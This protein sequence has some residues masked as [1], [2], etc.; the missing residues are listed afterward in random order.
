MFAE[1]LEAH[2]A[3]IAL[4]I[5][6]VMFAAFLSER[7]APEIVAAAAAAT[8]LGLGFLS[9]DEALAAFSNPAPITIAAMFILSGA[10][11]RTG[12][13][14]ALADLVVSRAQERPILSISAF[15]LISML[16]SAVVNNT[17]VVLVLIPVVIKLAKAIGVAPTRLLIPLSYTAI[18][19]GTL[20]LL[21]T[22]T[23]LLVDGVARQQ[24]L[25]PFGI[26]EITPYGIITALSGLATMLLLGKFLLPHREDAAQDLLLGE[27]EF[28][29]EVAL[30]SEELDGK[31]IADLAELNRP[32]IVVTGVR[33]GT[34]VTRSDLNA[35]ELKKGDVL[36]VRAPTSEVLTLNSLKDFRVGLRSAQKKGEDHI[37]VEAVVSPRRTTQGIPISSL[38][39]GRRFG[40]RILG[41]HR[42]NHIPGPE[43]GAVRLKAADKLLIEGPA[44]GFEELSAETELVSVSHPTG[45]AYRR[46][47]APIALLALAGVVILSAMG[48]MSIGSLALIAVALLLLLRCIDPDEAWDSLNG[49]VLVLIFSM[50]MVGKALENTGAVEMIV[51]ALTPLMTAVPGFAALLLIYLAA[52]VM[53]EMVTN[54]AVAVVLT[55]V[56]IG[57]AEPLGIDAR[58]IVMTVMFGA[59]ASFATPIGYQ[60][61]TLVYGAANYQFSDFLKIGVPMN[62]IVGLV[63][64]T[65][66]WFSFQGL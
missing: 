31:T 50:L 32:G 39:L 64:T 56:V 12:V 49:S 26:F 34:E 27:T 25:E 8:C 36:I 15:V 46:S 51:S 23:N 63:T 54:N 61:N 41:A 7:L 1:F 22:S 14:D 33:R 13:L 45:R 62:L 19:G 40:I 53:T 42:H 35:F 38:S 29:T 16:A 44:A 66:I 5:L 2:Q 57:L 43:L 52:S 55:P 11:V 20:S 9:Q 59:S 24:G 58:A 4:L 10:L 3:L 6:A 21:G 28:L 60:T 37:V 30:I 47:K 48:F 65:A 17:P 18:L